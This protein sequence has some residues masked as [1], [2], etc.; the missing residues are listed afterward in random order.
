MDW[1]DVLYPVYSRDQIEEYAFT[2]CIRDDGSLY[3]TA[4]GNKCR[5][6][7]ETSRSDVMDSDLLNYLS[8]KS[9]AK[10]ASSLTALNDE[11]FARITTQAS[12]I[13]KDEVT[14]N[15][16]TMRPD[17]VADIKPNADKLLKMYDDPKA[18]FAKL[19]KVDDKEVDAMMDLLTPEVLN[20]NG[21]LIKSIAK[22][23][24]VS[25]QDVKRAVIK[26]FMEQDG[27]DLYT[28]KPLSLLNA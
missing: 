16:R 5:L 19:K 2:L 9:K 1:R 10:A 26:R 14:P 12:Q 13:V 15:I 27:K 20:R 4:D 17:Q 7:T 3:G 21:G 23:E 6:G 11:Q 22:N 24:G 25:T 28:G 18:Y 8:S